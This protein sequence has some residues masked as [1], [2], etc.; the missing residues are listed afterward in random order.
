MDKAE[1]IFAFLTVSVLSALSTFIYAQESR[2]YQNATVEPGDT[3]WSLSRRYLKDPQRWPEILRYNNLA[4]ADPTLALPGQNIRIPVLLIK[5]ELRAA[6]LTEFFRLV[7]YRRRESADWK[8]ASVGIELFQEDGVRTAEQS[9]ARIRFALGEDLVLGGNSFVVVRPDR[10]SEELG[11][12]VSLVAGE[13]RSRGVQVLTQT[14][15]IIP[16]TKESDYRARI[17][18]DLATMV[19]VFKGQADVEAKGKSVTVEAGFGAEVPAGEAPRAPVA[20]PPV[21]E[22]MVVD[23]GPLGRSDGPGGAPGIIKI[24]GGALRMEEIVAGLY[25]RSKSATPAIYCRIQLALSIAP[26]QI[27]WEDARP[28]Q[29]DFLLRETGLPDGM[30]YL[31]LAFRDELGF[32]GEFSSW[33]EVAID[34]LPPLLEI[35]NP[36]SPSWSTNKSSIRISGRTEPDVFLILGAKEIKLD[37]GG[38][39]EAEVLLVTGRNDLSLEATDAAGNRIQKFISIDYQEDFGATRL[40]AGGKGTDLDKIGNQRKNPEAE[41]LVG[42]SFGTVAISVIIGVALFLF[43]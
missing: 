12:G 27:L 32:E 41:R 9:S 36:Q 20:L 23:A 17:R 19:E 34:T 24:E 3:L 26:L 1:R 39:F 10:L 15:R 21:P 38:S 11:R 31:R 25:G 30:Y 33:K 8:P 37:P 40:G 42:L 5:E 4:G 2:F 35:E 43:F 28:A 14:A 6:K 16:K 7:E 22:T 29:K 13:L 18:S